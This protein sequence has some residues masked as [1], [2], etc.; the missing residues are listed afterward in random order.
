MTTE[1]TQQVDAKAI[2][3]QLDS[4]DNGSSAAKPESVE[5]D[6]F[7]DGAANA[8]PEATDKSAQTTEET[9]LQTL[10][11]QL[12]DMQAV[13]QQVNGR[14]RNAEGR[15]GGLNSELK[16]QIDAAKALKSAGADAPSLGEIQAAQE[17]PQAMQDLEREYPE[18]AKALMP[19]IQATLK[20]Q[21]AGIEKRLPREPSGDQP[22]PLTRADLAAATEELR[23]ELAIEQAHPGWKTT[24]KQGDF[25]G[26]VQGGPREVHLLASSDDPQD[27]I[28]L[29][30]MWRA[31]SAKK[32]DPQEAQRQQRL[33]SAAA[34]PTGRGSKSAVT[35]NVDDMSPQEYW[36]YLDQLDKQ[37]ERS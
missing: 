23:G 30:D 36:R 29:M 2:W 20:T 21:L 19:A 8:A 37:S 5:S 10:R 12:A 26:F 27:A 31:H 22:A 16:Q 33:N 3:D 28:R 4:E 18:F 7:G 14:L 17:S 24:V 6:S 11:K 15:I 34:L 9:E 35:K 13:V 32:P 25:I 1:T